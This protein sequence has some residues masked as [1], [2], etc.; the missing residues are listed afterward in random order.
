MTL[1]E[2][3]NYLQRKNI[4]PPKISACGT[5]GCGASSPDWVR[6]N[7]G[8]GRSYRYIGCGNYMGCGIPPR[9]G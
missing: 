4:K 9:C 6:M 7:I 8:C 3:K 2:I 5:W 1:F